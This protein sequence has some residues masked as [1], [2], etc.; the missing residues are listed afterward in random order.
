MPRKH[1]IDY[2][3][4]TI[5]GGWHGERER[6]YSRVFAELDPQHTRTPDPAVID[7]LS[8]MGYTMHLLKSA[9]DDFLKPY[10]LTSAK[11]RLLMWLMA[12]EK[13][14]F[15]DGLLPSQLSHFQGISPNTV[16]ALLD[17]LEEQALIRRARHPIDHRKRIVT[18]TE[19]GRERL[20]HIGI[21]YK[22]FAEATIT[23]LSPDER[24]Q[25]TV[26]LDKLADSVRAAHQSIEHVAEP[27]V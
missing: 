7:I 11:F 22:H 9:V 1:A 13:A 26:L 15:S 19:S 3:E 14:E 25:L 16:S 2:K 18:M 5:A 10:N 17:G 24:Q 12:C 21:A 27:R 20:E 8:R 6:F 4:D 23:Q